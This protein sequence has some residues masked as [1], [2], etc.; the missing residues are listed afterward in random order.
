MIDEIYAYKRKAY[1][2]ETDSMGIVHHSNYIR[3]MEE[4]R[5]WILQQMGIPFAEME[6]LGIM[7]TVISAE[8]RYKMPLTFDDEFTVIPKLTNFNGFQLEVILFR[9]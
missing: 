5:V 6:K 8:C 3:W 9:N 7:I 2:Y 1:Y 4:A